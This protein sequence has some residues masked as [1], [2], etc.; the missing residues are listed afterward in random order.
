MQ[1][2][3]N[4][5]KTLLAEVA[6][7]NSAAA[8][9]GWDMQTYMP[10]GGVRGRSYQRATLS[11]LAHLKFTSNEIG[12]LLEQLQPYAEGLD[13]DSDDARLVK[14]TRRVY[15]KRVKISPEWVAEFS[16]ATSLGNKAWQEARAANDFSHFQPYL[17]KNIALRRAYAGFFAP[18][19]HV[20]DPLLDDFEPG[21]KTSEVQAIF[22]ALRP[23]QVALIQAVAEKPQ[24]SSDFLHQQFDKQ[25]QWDFGVEVV[26]R[27]GYDWEHGR[28]D[29]TAH[30]FTTT[31]HPEDVRITTR[32]LPDFLPAG[33]FSTM[34]EAGHALYG[35]GLPL[36]LARS[37]LQGNASQAVSES[38]SRFW[39]NI[40]GRS[41]AFWEHFYPRL[42]SYFP[43]QLEGISLD[44][45]YRG[46]NRVQPSLIRVEADEATYNLHIM[47]RMELEI[48]L[49]EGSLE[50]ADLPQAWNER[51][52]A[53]L[54][55]TPPTDSDGVLQDVHWAG[56][57]VGYFP[58]YALGN[59]V[60]VQLYEALQK[61][62]PDL[63][64]QIRSGR[65]EDILGW[66]REKIHRH[67]QKFEPQDLVQRVT[68]SRIDAGPFVRYLQAKYGEIYGL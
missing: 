13:P 17:E 48:A 30:P 23:Q 53:Y 61:D 64:S 65:F 15:A 31:F 60:S 22:S 7:I 3:L 56:G 58:T 14:V 36:A 29:Y 50:A 44:T 68:G 12:E 18:Y 46:I 63:D 55:L 25:K 4:Q 33:M 43:A 6:D 52:Q 24:V 62:V 26:T 21:M 49:M 67:G 10:S 27:F 20:Y 38:Q 45:F 32:I 59:L 51:M 8:V 41:R 28:Q 1:A 2:K 5:L 16:Q 54:G 9:L 42:Q 66:M 37:T 47:L 40:I 19:A 57:M 34:H 39:E 35:Q 11:R